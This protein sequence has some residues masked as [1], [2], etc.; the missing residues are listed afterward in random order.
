MNVDTSSQTP[1]NTLPHHIPVVVKLVGP[2]SPLVQLVTRLSSLLPGAPAGHTLHGEV[3][4]DIAFQVIKDIFIGVCS[5]GEIPP[6]HGVVNIG[7]GLQVLDPAISI[8]S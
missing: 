6:H 5:L 3:L 1:V 2:G 7:D 8:L 4:Q